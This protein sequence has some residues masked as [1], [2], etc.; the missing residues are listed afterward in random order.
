MVEFNNLNALED[1]LKN[2]DVACIL[3]E[4]AMTNVGIILPDEGYWKAVQELARRYGALF[5][6]DETHTICAG[7]GGC[8]AEW[9]LKPDMLVFGKAIGSGIPGGTYGCTEEVAA[10]ISARLHL[11]DCDV[12]GIGGTLAGNALSLAAMRS[13]LEHLLTRENFE[14]MIALA[15][16]FN[17]GV[18]QEIAKS[19]LPWN[20]QRLGCRAEYTFRAAP[21]RNGGE[22]A[23]A[24]DFELERFLHLHALNRGVLLTPFHNMALMCPATSEGDVD[25]HTTAF[26]EAISELRD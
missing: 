15:V 17:G 6:A 14:W 24:S 9:K 4:P 25:Q 26:A 1:A 21:P 16:R 8:T 13:T 7:P 5:I 20:V 3:A 23:A 2:G 19:G 10:R 12:G 22:S 11:E 18:A